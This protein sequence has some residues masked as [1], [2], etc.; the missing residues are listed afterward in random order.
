MADISKDTFS[1]AKR[2]GKVVFQR[3]KNVP[4]FELNEMQ[5]AIRVPRS[6]E[7]LDARM[8]RRS[9]SSVPAQTSSWK[10]SHRR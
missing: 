9:W 4:D 2:Y 1:E 6:R 5:D 8:T 10:I 7:S 3:D